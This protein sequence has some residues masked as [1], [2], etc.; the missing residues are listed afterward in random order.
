MNIRGYQQTLE[1]NFFSHKLHIVIH[2]K[3]K[4]LNKITKNNIYLIEQ[5]KF[6]I[7]SHDQLHVKRI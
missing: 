2:S 1:D 4:I 7:I 5:K 6:L 3:R